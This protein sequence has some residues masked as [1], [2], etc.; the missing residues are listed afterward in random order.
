MGAGRIDD[1]NSF[2]QN[3]RIPTIP[4]VG[5]GETKKQEAEVSRAAVAG[6]AGAPEQVSGGKTVRSGAPLEDISVT[7]NRHEDFK[8]LG[9]DSDIR[10][11]DVEKA[12]SD[13]KKD[14]VLQQYQYFVDSAGSLHMEGSDGTV[15]QKQ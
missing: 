12:I 10:S 3:Y 7:F 13:M 14:Q 2:L 11:L 15:I 5:I 8:Y 1:Y 4:S 9:Q 6:A